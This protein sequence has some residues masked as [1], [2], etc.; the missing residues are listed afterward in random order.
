MALL[1]PQ[2]HRTWPAPHRSGPLVP[3]FPDTPGQHPLCWAHAA[4]RLACP[5]CQASAPRRPL[6]IELPR[7][8]PYWAQLPCRAHVALQ[9]CHTL[10][11]RS[12]SAFSR[13]NV[14][15]APNIYPVHQRLCRRYLSPSLCT[16]GTKAQ[17][18]QACGQQLVSRN[19]G[20]TMDSGRTA[21]RHRQTVML[22][23]AAAR[24]CWSWMSDRL[25]G[26]KL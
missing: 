11:A 2:L 10:S 12:L 22:S 25:P 8:L 26:K 4:V 13:Y 1:Q 20:A 16:E 17:K 23:P 3:C 14:T 18:E 24:G 15:T 7:W 19:A 6:P 9:H 5:L 21:Q